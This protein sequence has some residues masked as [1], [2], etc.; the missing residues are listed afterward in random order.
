MRVRLSPRD[1][2]EFVEHLTG[3]EGLQHCFFM[4]IPDFDTA[5][6]E[7]EV[8]LLTLGLHEVTTS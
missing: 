4:L 8:C 3:S 2:Y 7:K 1:V 5:V 6:P